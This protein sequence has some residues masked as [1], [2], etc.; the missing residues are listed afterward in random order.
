MAFA[1]PI[2]K[3]D[4]GPTALSEEV[5]IYLDNSPSHLMKGANGNLLDMGI[6][7]A[8]SIVETYPPATRFRFMENS[9]A[10]SAKTLYTKEQLSDLLTEKEIVN[11]GRSM[12]EIKER[13]DNSGHQ[14]EVYWISDFNQLESIRQLDFS[15]PIKMVP[16]LS[17]V[18]SN[19]YIDTVFLENAYLSGDFSNSLN[20]QLKSSGIKNARSTVSIFIEDRLT[21]TITIDLKEYIGQGTFELPSSETDLSA[22]R[23]LLDD[24]RATFDNQFFL[25]INSLKRTNIVEVYDDNSS[26][27]ISQLFTE[28]EF[29][30]FNRTSV[31]QIEV[32]QLA[33]ADLIVLNGVSSF[34]N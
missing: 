27:Y 23:L 29:F 6:K 22:L 11:V 10:N 34:S 18:T 31:K 5:L 32:E 26:F 17:E 33:N 30:D 20:I 3:E 16:L 25:S 24:T 1:Q 9:Y 7:M 13:I 19:I 12:D 4:K 2:L 15:K 14:G 28:N 21:G 8:Q